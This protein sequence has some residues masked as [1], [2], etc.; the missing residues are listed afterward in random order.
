VENVQSN[1][2]FIGEFARALIKAPPMERQAVIKNYTKLLARHMRQHM[3][4]EPFAIAG[5]TLAAGILDYE[6]DTFSGG[7]LPQQ[8]VNDMAEQAIHDIADDLG[9]GI[10]GLQLTDL[11]E[12]V[13]AV[14]AAKDN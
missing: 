9:N 4:N 2:D 10:D 8:T 1:A 11:Q 12:R 3:D 13:E 14:H 5:R 6:S 7:G